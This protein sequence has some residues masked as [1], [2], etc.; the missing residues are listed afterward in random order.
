MS[1]RGEGQVFG[2]VDGLA[3]FLSTGQSLST[4]SL[5]YLTSP[6]CLLTVTLMESERV[7]AWRRPN[8]RGETPVSPHCVLTATEAMPGMYTVH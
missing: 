1:Q 5:L 8:T 3:G 4:L 6:P 2:G 7:R